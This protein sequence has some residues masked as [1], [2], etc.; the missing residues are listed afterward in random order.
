MAK[1]L[2]D[3]DA[4]DV[5][6][7][8][9]SYGSLCTLEDVQQWLD[10]RPTVDAVE[11]VHGHWELTVHNQIV[12]GRRSVTAQCSECYEDKGEIWAGFFPGIPDNIAD[13]AALQSAESVKLSHYCPNCGAKMDGGEEE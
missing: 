12:N 11:V 1:R 10:E 13:S 7:I 9:C 5:E 4:A 6:R 3:A 2:I 8:Y